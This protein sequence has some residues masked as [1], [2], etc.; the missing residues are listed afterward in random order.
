MIKWHT[1]YVE[2]I[3]AHQDVNGSDTRSFLPKQRQKIATKLA[4]TDSCFGLIRSRQ[5]GIANR[6]LVG[7]H[8]EIYREIQIWCT[9]GMWL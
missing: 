1:W 8:T 6:W 3:N 2:A 4:A 9:C 5:H 7:S